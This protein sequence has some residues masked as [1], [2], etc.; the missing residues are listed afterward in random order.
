M[1]TIRQRIDKI[2]DYYCSSDR[3]GYSI[4]KLH[5]KRDEAFLVKF[6]KDPKSDPQ[7]L[8]EA[9]FY[10]GKY[11]KKEHAGLF[12]ELLA[13]LIEKKDNYG[14]YAT[15]MSLENAGEKPLSGKKKEFNNPNNLK[16]AQAY[17]KRVAK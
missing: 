1:K 14:A 2:H 12:Q 7:L 10:L 4:W 5:S 11:F 8:Y 13:R 15:M 9:I 17:L 6:I 16:Y 3:K